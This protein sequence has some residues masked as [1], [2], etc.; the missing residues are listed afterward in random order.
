MPKHIYFITGASGVGKTTLVSQLENKYGQRKNWVFLH[1][2]QIGVPTP[3]EMNE[4]YGSGEN[5]QRETTNIWIQKMLHE[6]PQSEVII[7]E[8]Q[9]NLNFIRDGFDNA[10]Y[11]DVTSILIDCSEGTMHQRLIGERMQPELATDEMSNWRKLLR[12]QGEEFG[13]PIIDTQELGKDES[14]EKIE[15]IIKADGLL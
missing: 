14:L 13:V 11:S 10:G 15:G 5:W 9:V 3:E 6:Y 12:E 8:G 1:H 4:Q 2:D 7:F